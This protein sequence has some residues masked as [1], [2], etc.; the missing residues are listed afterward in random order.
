M[1]TKEQ[2][3]REAYDRLVKDAQDHYRV[4]V[5]HEKAYPSLNATQHYGPVLALAKQASAR[6]WE[7]VHKFGYPLPETKTF[8]NR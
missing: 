4:L 7:F 6:V 5:S 2:K 8:Y 1:K 3:R